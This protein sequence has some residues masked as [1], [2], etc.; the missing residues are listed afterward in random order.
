MKK[1]LLVALIA[2]FMISSAVSA[3]SIANQGKPGEFKKEM[4][5]HKKGFET[6]T[7]RATKMAKLLDLTDAEKGKVKSLIE[8]EDANRIKMMDE[9]Q[10]MREEM[11]LKVEKQRKSNNE[12]LEKIIG[13]EKFQKLQ[14]M[15]MKGNEMRA[16][17]MKKM[18]D[19]FKNR[20]HP[21]FNNTQ[22]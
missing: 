20:R 15:R 11:R 7:M 3:Q 18:K 12:D 10:A 17:K 6:P 21:Q 1:N 13:K 9:M 2:L 22:K 14:D 19:K 16:D 5:S 4:R 8:K